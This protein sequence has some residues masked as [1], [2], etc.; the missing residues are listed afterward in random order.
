MIF[1]NILTLIFITL[2]SFVYF[3]IKKLIIKN[4]FRFKV[5]LVYC[6]IAK[7]TPEFVMNLSLGIVASA[8]FALITTSNIIVGITCFI[9]IVIAIKSAIKANYVLQKNIK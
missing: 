8:I 5:C 3:K 4:T 6:R 7:N 1:L 2:I 9:S